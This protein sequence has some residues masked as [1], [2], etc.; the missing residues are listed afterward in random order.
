MINKTLSLVVALAFVA[1]STQML[2]QKGGPK[3]VAPVV[4]QVVDSG[5]RVIGNLLDADKAV[6]SVNGIWIALTVYESGFLTPPASVSYTSFDC[7]GQPLVLAGPVVR[8]T[9]VPTPGTT[10]MYAG[11]PIQLVTL[12]SQKRLRPDGSTDPESCSTPP[13]FSSYTGTPITADMSMFVPP[14]TVR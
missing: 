10:A 13:L 14:F 3:P 12:A 1:G 8:Q 7:S 2:A 4:L 9:F 5:G 11:N 6:L